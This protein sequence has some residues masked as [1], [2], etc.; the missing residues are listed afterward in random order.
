M[1][2]YTDIVQVPSIY[3]KGAPLQPISDYSKL[4][5]STLREIAEVMNGEVRYLKLRATYSLVE[6]D[7]CSYRDCYRPA[8]KNG[9]C[10]D[11]PKG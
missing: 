11:H 6:T 4:P 9:R 8:H 1:E 3:V 7:L 2:E 10:D 5:L